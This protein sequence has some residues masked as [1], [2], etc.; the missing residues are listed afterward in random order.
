MVAIAFGTCGP[1]PLV[2]GADAELNTLAFLLLLLYSL[3]RWGSGREAV[4]GSVIVALK[5]VLSLVFGYLGPADV[6]EW[7]PLAER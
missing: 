1:V 6:A 2:T 7:K 3:F 4:I 5:L